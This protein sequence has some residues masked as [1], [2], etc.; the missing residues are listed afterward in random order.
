MRGAPAAPVVHGRLQAAVVQARLRPIAP[1]P[2]LRG[3]LWE[4]FKPRFAALAAVVFLAAGCGGGGASGEGHPATAVPADALLYAEIVVRPEGSQRDDALAAA[5]K[6]LLTDD[7]EAKIR[8]LVD[9]AF[10]ESGEKI[11]YDRDVKPWLGERAGVWHSGEADDPGVTVLAATDTDEAQAAIKRAFERSGETVTERSHRGHEYLVDGSGVAAGV[12]G[13]FVAVGREAS[14]KRTVDAAEG[15]SLAETDEYADAID[16]LEDERLAHFWVDTPAVLRRAP[17][18]NELSAVVPI[19][20]L[21]PIAGSFTADGE[22]LAIE[23]KLRG[24]D[25]S[26][27]PLLA[28][29]STPLVQELPGDSWAAAG[30]ADVGEAIRATVDGFAGAIG[31]LALRREVR[32]QTGLDLDRDLLDWIG[33]VAFFVRGTTPETLDGGLVIQPTDEDRAADAFTRIVGAIQVAAKV[34][35]Q[36]V[37]VAG[38][39][40]A[41]EIVDPRAPRPVVLARGSGLVV[42]TFGRA[43][44]E[45]ALGSGER[46]GDT[47]TYAEAE[48]LV[49]ME[50]GAL[51]SMPQV[52]ELAGAYGPDPDFE[53]ARPYLEAFSVVAAG[54]TV[55]GDEATGRLAAGLR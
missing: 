4:T 39:D 45:A 23:T 51:V 28:G 29:G 37:D 18:M 27:G 6:L 9:R 13:D 36:P 19:D 42:A 50:P 35:A 2:S 44:A 38:A 49:G 20:D 55:D 48:E 25:G 8:E 32:R 3:A 41:F 5:G 10:E 15:E 21:P 47:D 24:A 17:D 11:D 40:Q 54:M 7:P 22:R 30:S 1:L 16:A 53:E 34:R 26:F 31:G 12:V 52:L 14:F 43:A 46:L 33:H